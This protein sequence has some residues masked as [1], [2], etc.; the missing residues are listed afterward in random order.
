MVAPADLTALN[1]IVTHPRII[2]QHDWSTN[3]K[4]KTLPVDVWLE[5]KSGS[6][7]LSRIAQNI[8]GVCSIKAL[9]D[10]AAK[11]YK[12]STS[13]NFQLND[14]DRNQQ[15]LR[16]KIRDTDFSH[17]FQGP[18]KSFSTTSRHDDDE[19]NHESD[20][21]IN[22]PELPKNQTQQPHLSVYPHWFDISSGGVGLTALNNGKITIWDIENG[23]IR[24]KLKG[25]V[26]DVYVS[27]FFPSDFAVVSGG[28]DMRVKVWSLDNDNKEIQNVTFS[29]HHSRINDV[30]AIN[31]QHVLSASNDGTVILWDIKKNEQ[32]NKIVE[33]QQNSINCVSLIDSSLLACACSDGSIRFY[34]SNKIN[35]KETIS[36]IT[37]GSPISTLCYLS[38]LNQLIY[39][40]EQSI[41]GIYDIRQ[42]NDIPIHTWKEQR[43]K[44]TCIV[45]S[46]DQQGIL[47]TTTDG[48][49]FEYNKDELKSMSDVEQF[50]VRDFT[51]ADESILNGKVFNNKVYSICRDGLVRV[52]E[53]IE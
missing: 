9:A 15:Q 52:Y 3:L 25:H 30:H 16:I 42:L 51:G 2:I 43:G 29:G 49:C 8:H 19:N 10:E 41:I 26:E 5:F 23:E 20:P 45:P 22:V 4:M 40:T 34:N 31:Q 28:A 48:S 53:N 50:H 11:I 13:D 38:E 1:K 6:A 18:I 21:L 24:R 12:T 37:I 35:P 39:G 17:T 44:I 47:I 33:L 32:L 46:R 27:R 14:I 36:T 7:S